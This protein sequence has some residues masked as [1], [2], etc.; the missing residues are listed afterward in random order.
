MDA[1]DAILA[2]ARPAPAGGGDAIDAILARARPKES[3]DQILARTPGPAE[4]PAGPSPAAAELAAL[5]ADLAN[6]H[7]PT[8]GELAKRAALGAVNTFVGGARAV[9]ETAAHPIDTIT[10]PAR[11][12]QFER[13]VSDMV[14]LGYAQKLAELLDPKFAATAAPDQAAAPEFRSL[15]NLTGMALP[16]AASGLANAGTRAARAILPG[17]GGALG[18]VRGALGYQLSAPAMPATPSGLRASLMTV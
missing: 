13:G 3:F 9:G 12:R 15:G 8:Y 14:T 7:V 1:I 5:Q 4:P 6:S 2:K 11:R 17:A 18:A 10:S 16:G